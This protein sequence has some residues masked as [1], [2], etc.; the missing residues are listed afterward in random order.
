MTLHQATP[1]LHVVAHNCMGEPE[2]S[3]ATTTSLLKRVES[4]YM[5]SMTTEERLKEALRDKEN[6]EKQQASTS[7]EMERLRV[8]MQTQNRD[9]RKNQETTRVLHSNKLLMECIM[10]AQSEL[11]VAHNQDMHMVK[12]LMQSTAHHRGLFATLSRDIHWIKE[13]QDERKRLKKTN[14][15][16]HDQLIGHKDS[17]AVMEKEKESMRRKLEEQRTSAKVDLDAARCE[18]E[19]RGHALEAAQSEHAKQCELHGLAQA[20]QH[21]QMLSLRKQAIS[22]EDALRREIATL[23]NQLQTERQDYLARMN[24]VRANLNSVKS[25]YSRK[26][27]DSQQQIDDL[28][29]DKE[30]LSSC[31]HDLQSAVETLGREVNEA[32]EQQRRLEQQHTDLGAQHQLQLQQ[33]EATHRQHIESS[34]EDHHKSQDQLRAQ[35]AALTSQ[36]RR[37]TKQLDTDQRAN[38]TLVLELKNELDAERASHAQIAAENA[39]VAKE[40]DA[41]LRRSDQLEAE[42]LQTREAAQRDTA[43]KQEQLDESAT[44]L[45]KYQR[46][47]QQRVEALEKQLYDARRKGDEEQRA[48]CVEAE[49]CREAET[50]RDATVRELRRLAEELSAAQQEAK[51]EA[52]RRQQNENELVALKDACDDSIATVEQ[53]W[54]EKAPAEKRTASLATQVAQLPALPAPLPEPPP[55]PSWSRVPDDHITAQA[56]SR[57]EHHVQPFPSLHT[58]SRRRSGGTCK[59]SFISMTPPETAALPAVSYL[60]TPRLVHVLDEA[61]PGTLELDGV[62]PSPEARRWCGDRAE[63]A[64]HPLLALPKQLCT[65]PLGETSHNKVRKTYQRS[66]TARKPGLNLPSAMFDIFEHF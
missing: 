45:S 42:L 13:K 15:L 62:G 49:N 58:S 65:V 33:I 25:N 20:A 4:V 48:A 39:E 28:I 10:K 46:E 64:A 66:N 1:G 60:P 8:Q 17:L 43:S 34:L 54:P 7:E 56:P 32:Q 14:Q 18:S 12:D 55:M 38:T 44:A 52:S 37:L 27:Q 30:R 3:V 41:A 59:R 22:A 5:D 57:P 19:E 31:M 11:K 9:M 16:L 26:Q 47:G 2:K 6:A 40:R 29:A 21:A 50:Q 24:E 35:E 53:P 23:D 63:E 61:V 36:V 51:L